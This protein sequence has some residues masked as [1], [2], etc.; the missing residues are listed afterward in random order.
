MRW[1]R[2]YQQH[3]A[4]H[5]TAQR[6]MSLFGKTPVPFVLL[7]VGFAFHARLFARLMGH[8]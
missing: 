1:L 3:V 8:V 6:I 7:C 2:A 5:G 4:W